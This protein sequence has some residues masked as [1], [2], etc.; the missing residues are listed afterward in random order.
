MLRLQGHAGSVCSTRIWASSSD[1]NASSCRPSGGLRC[2][3]TDDGSPM[4]QLDPCQ[5]CPFILIQKIRQM[6]WKCNV[7]SLLPN[8]T[9]RPNDD[10]LWIGHVTVN[11][12][13]QWNVSSWVQHLV[14]SYHIAQRNINFA[15][16]I[17]TYKFWNTEFYNLYLVLS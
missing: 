17:F 8:A 1:P 9:F 6:L 2:W 3:W 5:T 11:Q 10:N 14:P 4:R 15:V 7:T 16:K 13:H 12:W